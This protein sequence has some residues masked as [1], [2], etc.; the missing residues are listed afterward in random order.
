MKRTNHNRGGVALLEVTVSTLVLSVAIVGLLAA[1]ASSSHLDT[2]S[3]EQLIATGAARKQLSTMRTLPMYLVW[4]YNDQTFP[5]AGLQPT[6]GRPDVGQIQ[7]V[8]LAADVAEVTI[9]LEWRGMLGRQKMVY[10]TLLTDLQPRYQA[11]Y[12]QTR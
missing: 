9:T 11:K 5:V 4:G 8:Q 2:Q 12:R 10:R 1:L 6:D 7:V 3:R